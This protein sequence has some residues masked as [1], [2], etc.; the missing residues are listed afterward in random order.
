M[1]N[2]TFPPTCRPSRF[3]ELLVF[4]GSCV[5][6]HRIRCSS[7]GITAFPQFS[8]KLLESYRCKS[9]HSSRGEPLAAIHVLA[10][11]STGERLDDPRR[12]EAVPI[13]RRIKVPTFPVRLESPIWPDVVA[14]LA[15]QVVVEAATR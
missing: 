13:E 9:P 6:P 4:L 15:A 1:H 8:S 7:F 10:I 2:S 3:A 11:P 5:S 12:L 14:Q